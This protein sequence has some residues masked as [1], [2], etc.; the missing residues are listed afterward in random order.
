MPVPDG[1]R[2]GFW[3]RRLTPK[4]SDPVTRWRERALSLP[5]LVE[6]DADGLQHAGSVSP[7]APRVLIVGGSVAFGA[8]ADPGHARVAE[9]LAPAVA[10]L[11]TPTARARAP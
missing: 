1:P 3:G 2:E 11:L 9:R 4:R 5:G 10:R 8:Y 7:T 6:I